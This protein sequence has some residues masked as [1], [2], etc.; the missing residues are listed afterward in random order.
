[1]H[2]YA[3]VTDLRNLPVSEEETVAKN[4]PI[5]LV[6]GVSPF[7]VRLAHGSESALRDAEKQGLEFIPIHVR[8]TMTPFGQSM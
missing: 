3:K 7:D 6:K 1:M 4:L 5:E 2:F 8:M